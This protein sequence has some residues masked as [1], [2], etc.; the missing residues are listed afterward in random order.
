MRY[1]TK[2]VPTHSTVLQAWLP[3]KE[4]IGVTSV[5]SEDCLSPQKRTGKVILFPDYDGIGLANYARLFEKLHVVSTVQFYWLPDW[6]N[7]L[8]KFGNADLWRKPAYN[9]RTPMKN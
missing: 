3:F 9:S 8:I 6:E 1:A 2:S 5:H 7:K 4:L